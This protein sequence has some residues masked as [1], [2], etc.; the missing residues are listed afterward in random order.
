MFIVCMCRSRLIY[1]MGFYVV[2]IIIY[3]SLITRTVKNNFFFFI[4]LIEIT[5]KNATYI[6]K[7]LIMILLPVH[8]SNLKRNL[9]Y[10]KI[11]MINIIK[12]KIA[13]KV[14]SFN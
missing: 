11:E 3:I 14:N 1:L 6:H 10:N 2:I 9:K 7:F 4:I 12:L 8:Y 5:R 13:S